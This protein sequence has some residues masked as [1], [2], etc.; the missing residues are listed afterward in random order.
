MC[1]DFHS[2]NTI[3]AGQWLIRTTVA[4]ADRGSGRGKGTVKGTLEIRDPS[5]I[6]A[7]SGAKVD[8]AVRKVVGLL[9]DGERRVANRVGTD[10]PAV[11]AR[12]TMVARNRWANRGV[13]AISTVAEAN[14]ATNMAPATSTAISPKTN[15]VANTVPREDMAVKTPTAANFHRKGDTAS[16]EDTAKAGMAK[17]ATDKAAMGTPGA[18][19]MAKAALETKDM[20]VTRAL[21]LE[22][23]NPACSEDR[24]EDP[25]VDPMVALR[26]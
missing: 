14:M 25:T 9:R 23:G 6:R 13:M 20:E 19:D 24:K 3:G 21:P 10:S 17:V 15:L 12:V 7:T 22:T 18:A 1:N 26:A 2:S 11:T 5:G 8:M 16:R 4:A